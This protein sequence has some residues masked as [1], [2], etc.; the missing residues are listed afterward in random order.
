MVEI[1]SLEGADFKRLPYQASRR[2][3]L[4]GFCSAGRVPGKP[5]SF[6]DHKIKQGS[7]LIGT[8]PAH[9][10]EG[11]SGRCIHCAEGDDKLSRREPTVANAPNATTRKRSLSDSR[12]DSFGYS[13]LGSRLRRKHI[14]KGSDYSS[15]VGFCAFSSQG[16][17]LKLADRWTCGTQVTGVSS[18]SSSNEVIRSSGLLRRI[19]APSSSAIE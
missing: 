11:D 19:S 16:K 5:L 13:I 14:S 8:T 6:L 17:G 9:H 1:S 7:S 4:A 10:I 18:R 3:H 12:L 2:N 15:T